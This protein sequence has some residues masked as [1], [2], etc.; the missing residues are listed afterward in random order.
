MPPSYAPPGQLWL[1]PQSQQEGLDLDHRQVIMVVERAYRALRETGS[2]NPVKTIIEAPG[3]RSLSYSMVA[4]DASSDTVCFKAVYE[5]DP[6]RTR[7][8]YRFHSFVFLCDDAT[9]A[10]IALMDVVTLGPLRSSA[11][12]A[13]FARTACPG[14]RSALVVGTG[15][16][17]QM[18]LPMLLAALPDLDRLQVFGTYPDGLRAVRDS[19]GGRDVEIADDLQKA[20]GE[21]DIVIGAAGLSVREEVRRESMKPGSV[22]VL[23]GYGVHADVYHGA[24]Y[25]IATDIAQMHATGDDLRAADGSLPQVDAELPDILLGRAAARR[26][27]RDVVFA[28]NSGMAVTDAALGRYIADRALAGGRGQ[29]VTF[30]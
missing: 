4:R 23:L 22:A 5:F 18:A 21:A 28:Y 15:V 9:G 7:D 26:D 10:P 16:Q 19:A 8:S 20:A 6:R 13:L 30:W 11:T 12:T 25:R 1:L 17:G 2:D 29:R 27:P 14:A 3:H 24:D